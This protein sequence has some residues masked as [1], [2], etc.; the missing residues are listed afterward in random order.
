MDEE[1]QS[2]RKRKRKRG[3]SLIFKTCLLLPG[4]DDNNEEGKVLASD[5]NLVYCDLTNKG[6]NAHPTYAKTRSSSSRG[7]MST[8]FKA[9]LFDTAMKKKM[10]GKKASK[11]MTESTNSSNVPDQKTDGSLDKNN[12]NVVKD[13]ETRGDS[14]NGSSNVVSLPSETKESLVAS[15]SVNPG[16]Q[17][18]TERKVTSPV[19]SSSVNNTG[20]H[21]LT[22]RKVTSPEASS[23]VNTSAQM[24]TEKKVTSPVASSSVINGS[25]MLTE[26]KAV[27]RVNSMGKK[28]PL[29]PISRL[30]SKKIPEK[31]NKPATLNNSTSLLCLFIV[32]AVLVSVVLWISFTTRVTESSNLGSDQYTDMAIVGDEL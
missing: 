2:K 25:Q 23:S 15:S 17:I 30:P 1:D 11:T 3:R 10:R 19:A 22:E 31:D 28:P 14:L 27:S 6:T 18:L 32:L 4:S 26:R 9:V 29:P 16:A 7:R 5:D 20:A 8:I 12:H 24:L 21:M 13:S